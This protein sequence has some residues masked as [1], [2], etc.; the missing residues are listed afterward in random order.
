MM[1]PWG[2]YF[3]SR[4]QGER[5]AASSLSQRQEKRGGT[6]HPQLPEEKGAETDRRTDRQTN[7]CSPSEADASEP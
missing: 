2:C 4:Q 6:G 7:G 3:E 1:C 5:L